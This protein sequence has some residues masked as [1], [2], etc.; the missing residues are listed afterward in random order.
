MLHSFVELNYVQ[1]M[2]HSFD[3]TVRSCFVTKIRVTQLHSFD[4]KGEEG[5]RNKENTVRIRIPLCGSLKRKKRRSFMFS[6]FILSLCS[7]FVVRYFGFILFYFIY[8]DFL[9]LLFHLIPFDFL[10]AEIGS[11]PLDFGWTCH[12]DNG[13]GSSNLLPVIT[14]ESAA[15]S[16][17]VNPYEIY[18]RI[19]ILEARDYYNLPPQNNPGDYERLVKENLSRAWNMKGDFCFKVV[20]LEYY[21][22]RVLEQKG[23]LQERLTHLMLSEPNIEGIM[24][25]SP[26]SDVRKEAYHFIE[27]RFPPLFLYSFDLPPSRFITDDSLNSLRSLTTGLKNVDHGFYKDFYR[28]FTDEE[29]RRS[30]GLPLP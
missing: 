7:S 3:R 29:F 22:L 24:E 12:F 10:I 6:R 11:Q 15:S 28:H 5:K 14:P 13:A 8:I 16:D 4:R 18:E 21:E 2:L 25:L 27:D 23:L 1:P 20:R 19:K 30:I 9:F 17:R 26:Y